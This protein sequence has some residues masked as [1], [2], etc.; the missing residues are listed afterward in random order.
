MN[1]V[2]HTSRV[3]V[4]IPVYHARFLAAALE[5]VFAQSRLPDEVIV[6]NDGSPDEGILRRA[7]VPYR[8]RVRLIEQPNQ[9]P[10]AARNTGVN[11]STADLIALLD[12][13]DRWLPHFLREQVTALECDPQLDLSY[14][15][16]LYVGDTPLAGR[17]FMSTCPSDGAATFERLLAQ[18]CTVLLSSVVARRSALVRAGLFDATLRR[19]QDFDMWLRMARLG[20]R[21]GYLRRVLVLRRQH[22]DNLSGTAVDEIERPLAVL[23]KTLTT[24]PLRDE[25]REIACRRVRQLEGALATERGKALLRDGDFEAARNAFAAAHGA[26]TWKLHAARI[27]LRLAPQLVRRVYLARAATAASWAR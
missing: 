22:R 13:D 2:S 7:L 23:R 20:S 3:A 19:G 12:A 17:T 9:G 26:R 4:I 25:E 6:V 21:I 18:Q 27:A 10:A 1:G 11:A 16:G 24:M 8:P 5:S 14:T 15:D